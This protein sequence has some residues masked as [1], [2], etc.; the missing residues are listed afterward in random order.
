[1]APTCRPMPSVCELAKHGIT[2]VDFHL[3]G[4]MTNKLMAAGAT[5]AIPVTLKISDMFAG[6]PYENSL[7]VAAA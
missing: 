6:M 7:V 2:D 3:S 5:A 1:M 4:A